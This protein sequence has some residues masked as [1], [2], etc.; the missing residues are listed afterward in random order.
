[1]QSANGQVAFVSYQSAIPSGTVAQPSGIAVDSQGDVFVADQG[2]QQVLMI[3][4][5]SGNYAAPVVLASGLGSPNS[6][7]LDLNGNLF[8]TDSINN[9]VLMLPLSNGTYGT[10]ETVVSG[11]NNPTGIAV[12]MMEDILVSDTGTSRVLYVPYSGN[13]Y[14]APVAIATG[15]LNPQGLSI[16][17]NRNLYI[18]ATGS[19]AIWKSTWTGRGFSTPVNW[20]SSAA[21]AAPIGVAVDTSSDLTVVSATNH[22]LVY[23]QW[24]TAGKRFNGCQTLSTTLTS[25]VAL[26]IDNAG[27][28]YIADAGANQPLMVGTAFPAFPPTNVGSTSP[29]ITYNFSI[30]AGT[31][32]GAL[33]V[34]TPT[35]GIPE[36]AVASPNTCQT[37]TY[38]Q[39]AMC[40]ASLVFT[41]AIAGARSGALQI[42][43]PNG[44]PLIT[45]F[46]SGVGNGAVIFFSDAARSYLGTGLASPSGVAVDPSGNVYVSDTGNNRIVEIPSEN[47]AYQPQTELSLS[48]LTEPMGLATDVT[49]TLYVSSNGNSRMIRIQNPGQDNQSSS[50][51]PGAFDGPSSLVLDY[52]GSLFVANTYANYVTKETWNGSRY[53]TTTSTS[54]PL[55][56]GVAL[57][58]RGW[59]YSVEPYANGIYRIPAP[60]QRLPKALKNYLIPVS[61]LRQPVAIAVDAFGNAFVVDDI[62]NR[63]LLLLW[64]GSTYGTPI[65]IDS[66]LNSPSALA[67]DS[68]GN[69][70][71]AD[72]GNNRIVKLS[73]TIPDT[74]A[75]QT[76]YVNIPSPDSPKPLSLI[77]L[78][79]QS[80]T[81]AT[82][83]YPGDFPQQ[84]N[85]SS[86][87]AGATLLPSTLCQLSPTF[88]PVQPGALLSESIYL[89]ETGMGLISNSQTISASGAALLQQT[90]SISYS[91]LPPLQY[92]M[93][94][95]PLNFTS[96]SGLAVTVSV[97]SGPGSIQGKGALLTITGAGTI[98]LQ[99]TQAG[100]I[101]YLAAPT[102]VITL[103]VAPAVLTFTATPVQSVYGS[104]PL[105]FNATV[106]GYVNKDYGW[107][108]YRGEG[109]I[110]TTATSRSPVGVYSINISMGTLV[111]ANYTFVFVP[112]TLTLMPAHLTINALPA[113]SVY[114]VHIA[115]FRYSIVGL[116]A[117]DTVASLGGSPYLFSVA[118]PTSWIGNYPIMILQG[119]ISDSNYTITLNP[120]TL[121][122]TPGVLTVSA[123]NAS[124]IYG[125]SVPS[126]SYSITGFVYPD[127]PYNTTSGAAALSTTAGSQPVPGSYSIQPSLGTLSARN[128]TFAFKSGVLTVQ[129][130]VLTV[131]PDPATMVYGGTVP[132]LT[133]S[134]SGFVFNDTASAAVAGSAAISTVAATSSV[135]T[136]SISANVGTLSS[137]YYSFAY[138]TGS[139][140]ITPAQLTVVPSAAASVY[141]W[142]IPKLSYTLQGLVNRDTSSVVS[143]APTL[144]TAAQQGSGAGTYP[145]AASQGTLSAKNYLF[146]FQSGA[147]TITPAVLTVSGSTVSLVYGVALP[148]LPYRISGF[149]NKDTAAAVAGTPAISTAASTMPVAGTYPY[150]VG[151]GTLAAANYTFAFLPGQ[152][153]VSPATVTVT[154]QGQRMTYGNPVP[155]LTYGLSGFVNGDAASVVS[156]SASCQTAGT[157][158]A[159]VGSYPITCSKG[160]LSATN[161]TFA[162]ANGTLAV[163]PAT[164]L[165]TAGSA[166]MVYGS[167]VAPTGYVVTGFVNG[168]TA[169]AALSG[170]P[171]LTASL[172]AGVGTYPIVV[173]AGTLASPNYN[174]SFAP[175]VLT[176][177]PAQLTITADNLTMMQ[178]AA[179]PNFTFTLSGMV[180]GDLAS[181]AA[182]GM[183][184][185]STSATS[186]S[187]AGSYTITIAQG[188]LTS[189]NYQL[190]LVNGTLTVSAA[191]SGQ[192]APGRIILRV[193]GNSNS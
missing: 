73:P 60:P 1:M 99:A 158:K 74:L 160:S 58:A 172:T 89:T 84:S 71:I 23:C 135:G 72:T 12:D 51:V 189:S 142:V 43:D 3:P 59:L 93:S 20:L 133:Y 144:N 6:L 157:P 69:I 101:G 115:P 182:T 159:M 66:D 44:N 50:L 174:F 17:G 41:P 34:F 136:Y 91:A 57:D 114:G 29:P 116:V 188:T 171:S 104:V 18:A 55:S 138:A 163:T 79:N 117:G 149:V 2:N 108:S 107:I 154:A 65:V 186:S 145:I 131:I 86:C 85:S 105:Q 53:A 175:G 191:T 151:P 146:V 77:N 68:M 153:V 92:G 11:L 35:T 170:A 103:S 123:T 97:V 90:Q 110:T 140:T 102:V 19:N 155:S 47:G 121:T 7:T 129:K 119:S 37:T 56:T 46:T 21:V 176:I 25:P 15:M 78:G 38:T 132:A 80:L 181:A 95:V 42:A 185:I 177:T 61:S 13:G 127:T 5:T 96:S 113:T 147:L 9:V 28:T 87:A 75:F 162:F 187:A 125:S 88:T 26:A 64:N 81:I 14:S 128:Y 118:T 8:V 45:A 161:Y 150:S 122:I 112:S 148:N 184:A 36:F 76:T 124:M 168:D 134:L 109:V 22:A 180:N 100:N 63:L 70:Y 139:M 16:D 164:L 94:P 152:V 67:L 48:G 62:T 165:V 39:S 137:A 4:S 190:N 111:S 82:L 178:G 183:P 40:S 179:L 173:A 193:V 166:T 49:G 130:A 156:G 169:A 106:T 143:G 54:M 10:P 27:D 192:R 31:T 120:S 52:A 141:G 83:S 24:N 30:A 167:G 32:L 126:L 33:S 98:T